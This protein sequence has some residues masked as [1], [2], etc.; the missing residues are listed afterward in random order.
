MRFRG[1]K[2]SSLEFL[3]SVPEFTDCVPSAFLAWVDSYE[4]LDPSARWKRLAPGGSVFQRRVWRALL[5]I[6]P[7]ATASYGKIAAVIGRPGAARAVGQAVGANPI[8]LLIPCHRVVKS[9]GGLGGYRW[10][11][12]RKHRLLAL[13]RWP[14]F[15]LREA[16]G[17]AGEE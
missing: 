2:P 6:P 8:A 11:A 3:D 16:L 15:Q 9:S 13:E 7:G 5:E 12:E 10:G 14:G 4:R 17:T 1:G